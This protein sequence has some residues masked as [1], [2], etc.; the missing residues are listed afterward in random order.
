MVMATTCGIEASDSKV[1]R[2]AASILKQSNVTAEQIEVVTHAQQIVAQRLQAGGVSETERPGMERAANRLAQAIKAKD[3][4]DL[5]EVAKTMLNY[6]KHTDTAL[7]AVNA[8][9]LDPP[10]RSGGR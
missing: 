7:C 1:L 4:A 6:A 3:F 5:K 8:S 2:D 9:R 10:T